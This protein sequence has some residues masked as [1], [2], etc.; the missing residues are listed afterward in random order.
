MLSRA[1]ALGKGLSSVGFRS[2]ATVSRYIFNHRPVR[3]SEQI[4]LCSDGAK[5]SV[6][7]PPG[8]GI[9]GTK[10]NKPTGAP[11]S[12]RNLALTGIFFGTLL[13]VYQYARKQK[14]EAVAKERKKMIGKAKIGGGFDLIDHTGKPGKSDD[15]LGQWCFF[16]FGFT[17]C[18]DICPE[19]LEKVADIVD[20]LEKEGKTIQPIFITVDPKRDG[21]REIAEYVK[22][23]HP[24]LIGFTGTEEQIKHACKSYRVY[25][26]QGP[27]DE[28]NDY[29]V[30]HTIIVYLIN[31]DGDFVDYYGQTKDA[32]MIRNSV[33][34]HMAKWDSANKKGIFSLAS[35]S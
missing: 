31:P 18:P 34:F 35:S 15:F 6:E 7:R 13:G 16:Y 11:I 21:V 10:D 27:Q 12:W 28:D 30:D 26:S 17:H 3:F 25:Y 24:K 22:E 8:V 29:I 14:E 1:V 5:G 4:R 19:E 20:M 9:R 33:K 32:E 23:F 2:S